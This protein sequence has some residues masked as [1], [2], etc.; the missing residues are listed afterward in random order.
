[1]PTQGRPVRQFH[2]TP[3]HESGLRGENCIEM[4]ERL[5][6]RRHRG[7]LG[8]AV[9][10]RDVLTLS[11]RHSGNIDDRRIFDC[12]AEGCAMTGRPVMGTVRSGSSFRREVD[13]RL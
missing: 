5:L 2:H 11:A 12:Q 10:A 4:I 1:M 8:Y 9:L 7:G 3:I 13:E 6:P